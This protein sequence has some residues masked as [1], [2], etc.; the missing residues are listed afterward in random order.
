MKKVNG[1][2]MAVAAALG[3]PSLDFA[4]AAEQAARQRNQVAGLNAAF[5]NMGIKLKSREQRAVSV[6]TP[7]SGKREAAR[8]LRQLEAQQAKKLKS[9]P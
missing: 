1:H 9:T 2:A 8:R 4:V 5:A 3:A 6:Y 7:H